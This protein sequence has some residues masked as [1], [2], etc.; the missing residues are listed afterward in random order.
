MEAPDEY[1]DTGEFD[2][3]AAAVEKIG[4]SS[5]PLAAQAIGLGLA[6]IQS[7]IAPYP[8]QPDRMRARRFNTY[9]RGI[10]RYPRDAFELSGGKVKIRTRKAR[11]RIHYTSQQMNQRFRI[12]V[13]ES[14]GTI[15]G[16]LRSDATYSGWVL[17]TKDQSITPHQVDYHALTGWVSKDDAIAQAM[18][19]IDKV[20]S[21][22]ADKVIQQLVIS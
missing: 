19:V 11:G 16:E 22:L 15:R 20:L 18:P 2:R 7:I 1:L 9:V 6:E 3:F 21:D 8:P 10:G 5:L 17:G 14:G 13:T 4:V 12:T